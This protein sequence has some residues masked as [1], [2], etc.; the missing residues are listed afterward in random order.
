V[1]LFRRREPLHVR[2]ARESGLTLGDDEDREPTRPPWDAPGI[3]ALQRPPE[4]DVVRTVEAPNLPGERSGF[5]ALPGG[6]LVVEEGPEH[7]AELADAVEHELATPFRVE[8][9][10]RERGLWAVGAKR[11][12]LI[13]LPGV[14][15]HEIE[16]TCHGDE[17][18][19]VVD[20]ERIFGSIPQLERPGQVVRARRVQGEL[21]EVEAARL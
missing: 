14:D 21:W 10:K 8:A 9:V 13:E 4:W 2:L 7:P 1:S 5:V 6:T 16:V 11:V 15:G 17:R 12:E 3:H 20:G 18:S 19:A